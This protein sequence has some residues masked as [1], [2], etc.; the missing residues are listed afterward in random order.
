MKGHVGKL[1]TC[2][3][4]V[5]GGMEVIFTEMGMS[6]WGKIRAESLNFDTKKK[7][8]KKKTCGKDHST[9]KKKRIFSGVLNYKMVY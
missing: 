6:V 9:L 5:T 1:Q 7:K 4:G 3:A 8:K 2:L